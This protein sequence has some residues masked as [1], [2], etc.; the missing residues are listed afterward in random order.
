MKYISITSTKSL[1]FS[2]I[3]FTASL[4]ILIESY[5]SQVTA[6]ATQA[7][8]FWHLHR[9]DCRDTQSYAHKNTRILPVCHKSLGSLI[10][11]APEDGDFVELVRLYII[12]TS[13]RI[14]V[15][16]E[17]NKT[18]KTK[19]SLYKLWRHKV[20]WGNSSTCS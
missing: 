8:G 20:K 2:M 6:G 15:R 1:T 12:E 18:V 11:P 10:L 3:T 5:L 13:C 17:V 9:S 16:R 19:V 4:T 7:D 14:T